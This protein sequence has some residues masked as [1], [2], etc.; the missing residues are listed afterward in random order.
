MR[1]HEKIPYIRCG[2]CRFKKTNTRYQGPRI[3][4]GDYCPRCGTQLTEYNELHRQSTAYAGDVGTDR[5]T[6]SPP[7]RRELAVKAVS[8]AFPLG[9]VYAVFQV[10]IATAKDTTL[11]INGDTV[12]LFDPGVANVAF[13]LVAFVAVAMLVLPYAPGY[14][15]HRRAAA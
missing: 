5:D 2:S 15:K 12:P 1:R 7:S 11:T 13:G 8:L 10:F 9:L 4:A 6:W 14:V 3:V